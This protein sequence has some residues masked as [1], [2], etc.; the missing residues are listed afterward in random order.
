MQR[1]SASPPHSVSPPGSPMPRA[2]TPA[3]RA[4]EL[5]L[6]PVARTPSGS[7]PPS[8]TGK[9]RAL[10]ISGFSRR[11]RK[12]LRAC[13]GRLLLRALA[14]FVV[15]LAAL[16]YFVS[17]PPTD[18][19]NRPPDRIVTNFSCPAAPLKLRVPAAFA[20]PAKRSRPPPPAL[21]MPRLSRPPPKYLV[22]L[23]EHNERIDFVNAFHASLMA[24]GAH[25]DAAV[26]VFSLDPSEEFLDVLSYYRDQHGM[27]IEVRRAELPGGKKLELERF[28]WYRDL[29]DEDW[30]QEVEMI[31]VCDYDVV[32]QRHPFLDYPVPENGIAL[33]TE[34]SSFAIGDCSHHRQWLL[35][36]E[37]WWGAGTMLRLKPYPRICAGM[38][39]GYRA[40]AASLVGMMA[41]EIERTGCNDQGIL[42]YLYYTCLIPHN[43]T[44]HSN[45][46]GM[47]ATVG[48]N[49]HYWQNA[50]GD[51][52]N[53]RGEVQ[54]WVHQYK[55][56]PAAIAAY[57]ARYPLPRKGKAYR[58]LCRTRVWL[59]C[60][61]SGERAWPW[62]DGRGWL[63]LYRWVGPVAAG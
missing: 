21:A 58:V 17:L 12:A 50:W 61:D 9:G 10:P 15:G 28:R 14:A 8:P 48:S 33:S 31:M 24:S 32:F 3:G 25:R 57:M 16:S 23:A 34:W 55:W 6:L 41:S 36:G 30:A 45:E 42:N 27:R 60:W 22:V 35:C 54:A 46:L 59:W 13:P 47:G 40:A 7:P 43:V 62:L 18:E 5:P 51:L 20:E 49:P 29:M 19:L 52:V 2:A 38:L 4:D 26:V 39:V 37:P 1:A 56:H 53:Q 63:A 44:V 11:L